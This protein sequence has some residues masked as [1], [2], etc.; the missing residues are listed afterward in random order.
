M[1]VGVPR[2]PVGVRDEFEW[3]CLMG[4]PCDQ[5]CLRI[6][7]A[8]VFKCACIEFR[9]SVVRGARRARRAGGVVFVSPL[10]AA[11]LAGV[12]CAFDPRRGA[13]FCTWRASDVVDVIYG[14]TDLRPHGKLLVLCVAYYSVK[15]DPK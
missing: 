13:Q 1:K 10:C 12:A 4:R 5:C 8:E 3:G 9:M 2:C 6:S 7:P 14:A 11:R 15:T